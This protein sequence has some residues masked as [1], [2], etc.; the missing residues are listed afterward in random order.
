M[1]HLNSDFWK[2]KGQSLVWIQNIAT[3]ESSVPSSMI[4]ISFPLDLAESG[5]TNPLWFLKN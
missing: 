5:G 3:T 4:N 1:K 2:T